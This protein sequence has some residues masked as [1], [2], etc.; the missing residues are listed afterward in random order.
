[1]PAARPQHESLAPGQAGALLEGR[2]ARV[3]AAVR[4][5]WAEHIPAAPGLALLAVGGFGRRELFPCSDVD[6]LVLAGRDPAGSELRDPLS[7]FLRDLWDLGFRVSH[8]VRT[9]EE[10]CEVHDSNVELNA[11]LLDQRFLAGDEDLHQRLA[12][13]LSRFLQ[14]HREDLARRLCGLARAR[15]AK[16]QFTIHH[17]EPDVKESPGGLRDLHLI[18]WLGQPCPGEARDFLHSVRCF[19]H[20]RAGRDDNRL[21]F[22]AQEEIAPDPAAWMRQYYRHAR[23]IQRAALRAMEAGEGRGG[24]LVAG[25]RD[26]RARLSNSEFT[27]SRERVYVRSGQQLDLDPGLLTR[28]FQFVAR[29]G[30]R[31]ALDTERRIGERL[32]ALAAHFGQGGDLWPALKELLSLPHAALALRSMEDSGVLAALLPEWRRIE[33]LVVRDFYH[34][35]TVDEHTLLAIQNLTDLRSAKTPERVR[36]AELFG[37]IDDPG[38]LLFALLFHDT[39]KGSGPGR[40]VSESLRLAEA[41][42][43]RLRMPAGD[44]K[45]VRF[46]IERHLDLPAVMNARDLDDPAT[47]RLLAERVETVESL[48]MLTLVTYADIS[49]VHP[50]AMT[51]WRLEQL[52]RVYL[53]AHR[54]LTRELDSDRIEPPG[55]AGSEMAEFMAGFPVRYLRTHDE[56]ESEEHLRM[57]RA[58]QAAGV[59]A[60]LDRRA[61]GWRLVV[62]T[63]DRPFLFASLAGALA[64]F[65][66]NILKAEAFVNRQGWVLDTFT[67]SDPM[68]T[69]ELNLAELERLRVTVER[70][71]LGKTDVRELLR[72][73]PR[74]APPSRQARIRPRVSFDTQASASATLIEIVA[75]D[76]PGL[77]YDL[78]STLS[79]TGC[80]IEVVLIDTEAH[81]AIDVF[82]VTSGGG[83]L[84]ESRQ[85]VLRDQ[86][87]GACGGLRP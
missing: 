61:G 40:H 36:F 53:A 15:H 59:V 43:E 56:T 29:H 60:R 47:A 21:S 16:R 65:G 81:K 12:Q 80:N 41:A 32:P 50:T 31:P 25:F 84:E 74:P 62:V 69:L 4:G 38:V 1:M 82:Y 76:R 77:L 54:E 49:A 6:L 2:T 83:K 35:Y 85:S 28:L 52:W 78:A 22:D 24:A 66:M 3:E 67:F 5:V 30:V 9:I 63:R 26:W 33:C 14:A 57:A 27:V 42:M 70:A 20:L 75:Q 46:L 48:K 23:D 44:R 7:A 86:L 19:L 13:R 51:P 79:S 39:G 55:A 58:S 87:L 11:S 71:A 73:R 18:R 10:C 37:E 64:S 8:S 68:R 34:R 17:L 72:N 45:T